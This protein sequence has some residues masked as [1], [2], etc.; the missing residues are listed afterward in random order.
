MRAGMLNA[1][2]G[3]DDSEPEIGGCGGLVIAR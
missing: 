1:N 2:D 3:S